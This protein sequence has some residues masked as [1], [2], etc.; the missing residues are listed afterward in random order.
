MPQLRALTSSKSLTFTALWAVLVIF[1]TAAVARHDM[2]PGPQI[3]GAAEWPATSGVQRSASNL[4]LIM[5][6]HPQCACSRASLN[7]LAEI[8]SRAEGR[9]SATILFVAPIGATDAFVHGALWNQARQVPGVKVAIDP[10]G[11]KAAAFGAAT[12]G[13]ILLYASNEPATRRSPVFGCALVGQ[14][15]P[16]AGKGS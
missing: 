3:A 1:G 15:A 4:T 5:A 10:C 13:Q 2:Q 8:M 11:L 12:S 9:L 16:S 6:V 14:F 7:E